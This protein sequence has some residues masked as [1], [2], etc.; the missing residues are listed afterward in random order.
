[1]GLDTGVVCL[2]PTV[3]LVRLVKC[4]HWLRDWLWYWR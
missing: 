4:I 3:D 1:M 2:I